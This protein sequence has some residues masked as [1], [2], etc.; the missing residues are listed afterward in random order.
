MTCKRWFLLSMVLFV[1]VVSVGGIVGW[2][3][4]Q[5]L[6][7]EYD[8]YRALIQPGIHVAGVPVGGLTSEEAHARV[9]AQVAAPYY[10]DFSLSYLDETMTL[11][12]GTDLGLE[13]P[14]DE[15]V[16]EAV[17]SSHEYDYW[18]GFK[19]WVQGETIPLEMDVPL[20]MTF[21]EEAAGQYLAEVAGRLDIPPVE[22]MLDLSLIHI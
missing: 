2:A 10:R 16:N 17:E 21:D 20:Q 14:V 12:P 7:A 9:T 22:P 13:I 19:L 3:N 6:R 18:E 11:A 4:Y 1:L 5:R 15:M 8:A